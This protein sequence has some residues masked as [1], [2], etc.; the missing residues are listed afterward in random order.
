MCMYGYQNFDYMFK[1][2]AL[3]WYFLPKMSRDMDVYFILS[4]KPAI[5]GYSKVDTE[6]S[7]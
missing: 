2:K 3:C 1:Y 7:P 6:M 5:N 4:F